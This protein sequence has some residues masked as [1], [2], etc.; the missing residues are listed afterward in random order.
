MSE[1]ILIKTSETFT[2]KKVSLKAE[3]VVGIITPQSPVI[4][5]YGYRIKGSES[6]EELELESTI[7]ERI[8]DFYEQCRSPEASKRPFHNCH[9]LGWY[10]LGA[11]SEV[12]RYTHFS[13]AGISHHPSRS[14]LPGRAYVTDVYNHTVLGTNRPDHSLSVLGDNQPM[15]VSKNR[16]LLKLYGATSLRQIKP[17]KAF[18]N[19]WSD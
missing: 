9:I 14:L 4:K 10:A 12:K 5:E 2:D 6:E 8:A 18:V 15:V 13:N 16:G 7:A 11:V 17:L 1:L 3:R 19:G